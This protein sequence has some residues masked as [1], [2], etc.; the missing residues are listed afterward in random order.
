MSE[1]N[2]TTDAASIC[3]KPSGIKPPSSVSSLSGI[4]APSSISSSSGIKASS[5]SSLSKISRICSHHDK[6]PELPDAATPKKS[7]YNF[8]LTNS[9]MDRSKISS[10]I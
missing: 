10:Y 5:G 4:K 1:S 6:K 8:K 7:E 2:D 9:L 3:P